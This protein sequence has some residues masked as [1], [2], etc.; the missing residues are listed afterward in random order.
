M[1]GVRPRMRRLKQSPVPKLLYAV[2]RI[3]LLS[4]NWDSSKLGHWMWGFF[5]VLFCFLPLCREFEKS[6][7]PKQTFYQPKPLVSPFKP[8]HRVCLVNIYL[9]ETV[10]ECFI[11][12]RCQMPWGV[13]AYKLLT[14]CSIAQALQSLERFTFIVISRGFF[15]TAIWPQIWQIVMPALLQWEFWYGLWIYGL[16]AVDSI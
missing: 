2:S 8:N 12:T 4:G 15:L 5:F 1:L 13:R 16:S 14:R 7:R 11:S 10:R 6:S 9:I 3:W